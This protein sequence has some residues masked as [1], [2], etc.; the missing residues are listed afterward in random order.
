MIVRDFTNGKKQE[1]LEQIKEVGEDRPW[2]QP[3]SLS[4]PVP[5]EIY[6]PFRTAG[7]F[8]NSLNGQKSERKDCTY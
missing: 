2:E 3:P 5:D 1:L 8:Y 4:F 6:Q 7:V